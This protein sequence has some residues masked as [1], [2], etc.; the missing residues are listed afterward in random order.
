MRAPED[1]YVI[2][3]QCSEYWTKSNDNVTEQMQNALEETKQCCRKK[4]CHHMKINVTSKLFFQVLTNNAILDNMVEFMNGIPHRVY[5]YCQQ[6]VHR[7][8]SLNHGNSLIGFAAANGHLHIVQAIMK[9]MPQGNRGMQEYA[10]F[11]A[12]VTG[13]IQCLKWLVNHHTDNNLVCSRFALNG[14]AKNG[15]LPVVQFLHECGCEGWTTDAMNGA[16]QNGHLNVVQFLHHHRPEGCTTFAMN[17]AAEHGHLDVVRF[18]HEHRTEGCTSFA[19]NSAA[20]NGHLDIVRFLHEHRTEG[21]T[22]NAMTS[23]AF[24]GHL[25]VVQFLHT[26]RTEGCTAEAMDGAALYGHFEIVKFL[27]ENRHEGCTEHAMDWAA[28]HGCLEIVQ[29]LYN[30]RSEGSVTNAMELSSRFGHAKIVK[31]CHEVLHLR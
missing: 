12:I 28:S 26:H 19:M 7:G 30:N 3:P 1:E 23:A 11:C 31:W 9:Y 29:Y 10:I 2:P 17:A 14:A 22:T 16:S 6:H 25:D 15:H 21:C 18:L 27:H 20:K 24:S 4:E 8:L 13:Q 5:E